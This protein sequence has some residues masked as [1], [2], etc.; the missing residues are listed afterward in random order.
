MKSRSLP[1]HLV[2]KVQEPDGETTEHDRKVQ[3]GEERALV[4]EGDL[5]LDAHGERDALVRGPLKQRLGR[6]GGGG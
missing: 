1:T 5:R 3:P 2:A 6:H 4:R